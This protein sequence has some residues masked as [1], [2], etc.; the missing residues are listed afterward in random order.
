[1]SFKYNL[2]LLCNSYVWDLHHRD[3]D[4]PRIEIQNLGMAIQ[5]LRM[6]IQNLGMAIQHLGMEIQHLGMEIQHLGMAI[7][8]RKIRMD[9]KYFQ[10]GKSA[11]YSFT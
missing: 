6:E 5:H 2:H 7:N 1:M 3:R 8:H 10:V 9:I 4:H 11:D